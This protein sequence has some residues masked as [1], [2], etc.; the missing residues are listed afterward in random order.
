MKHKLLRSLS[1]GFIILI[2]AFFSY[3]M[4]Y[5]CC[6]DIK[7]SK[8]NPPT[9]TNIIQSAEFND[10]LLKVDVLTQNCCGKIKDS[11]SIDN[12][13]ISLNI[14]SKQK[15]ECKLC[16]FT[17]EFQIN[18]L[19]ESEYTITLFVND[20]EYDRI[21]LNISNKIT[22]ECIDDTTYLCYLKNMISNSKN[23]VVDIPAE[24]YFD[25][26][27][28]ELIAKN[29]PEFFDIYNKTIKGRIGIWNTY[30]FEWDEEKSAIKKI[31]KAN[32][33]SGSSG[34]GWFTESKNF[35]EGIINRVNE[36]A[37]QH[38]EES[39]PNSFASKLQDKLGL[40]IPYVFGNHYG[41]H[42]IYN[43][44]KIEFRGGKHYS[45]FDWIVFE[46]RNLYRDNKIRFQFLG[47]DRSPEEL[48]KEDLLMLYNI[49]NMSYELLDK[50]VIFGREI[51]DESIDINVSSKTAVLNAWITTSSNGY[52]LIHNSQIPKFNMEKHRIMLNIS[53]EKIVILN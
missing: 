35:E 8:W 44:E 52:I 40:E 4:F 18:D 22:D 13:V 26:E 24:I 25:T 39:G 14:L 15:K 27:E 51:F 48:T 42:F 36:Y 17:S 10:E 53:S 16:N 20:Q 47:F 43:N 33:D 32:I 3:N 31:R 19:I 38:K 21:I 30:L 41:F 6:G 50:N 12:D 28:H 1:L 29:Y 46:D 11:Y 2:L 23:K 49:A 5:G 7:F 34:S 37:D 45:Q 9:L